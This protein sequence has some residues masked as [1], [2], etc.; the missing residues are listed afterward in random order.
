MVHRTT[1]WRQQR[2][3]GLGL[4]A[5]PRPARP[6]RRIPDEWQWDRLPVGE[7]P[8]RSKP[9]WN[10]PSLPGWMSRG[11]CVGDLDSAWLRTGPPDPRCVEVCGGCPVREPCAEWAVESKP[12]SS[13]VFAGRVYVNG[14]PAS[15]R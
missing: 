14:R 13:G 9:R 12:K 7:V 8:E 6:A 2:R 11:A 5:E 10:L 3:A 4:T 1:L 15:G